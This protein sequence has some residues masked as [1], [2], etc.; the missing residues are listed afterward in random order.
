[1]AFLFRGI[2]VRL[3]FVCMCGFMISLAGCGGGPSTG[4]VSGSITVGGQPLEG[5]V[6]TFEN[7]S[8]GQGQS[9]TIT[10]GAYKMPSPMPVGDYKVTLQAP[11]P[12]SP[13]AAPSTAPKTSI[14]TR[15]M[16]AATSDLTASVKAGQNKLDFPL[17]F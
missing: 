15:F 12:P 5:G 3:A 10:A 14:P 9:A 16:K 7:A 2:N 1:M 13:T 8:K 17:K 11:P 6:V 4:E